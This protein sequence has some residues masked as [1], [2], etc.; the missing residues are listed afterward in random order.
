[1]DRRND[2]SG[3]P[4]KT[5]R[6][7]RLTF[8]ECSTRQHHYMQVVWSD[9][10]MS[11]APMD[12]S[13]Q[14][15]G[16]PLLPFQDEPPFALHG[17]HLLRR[18]VGGLRRGRGHVGALS[19][20]STAAV[21]VVVGIVLLLVAAYMYY[22]LVYLKKR[23]QRPARPKPNQPQSAAPAQ[24]AHTKPSTPV[25]GN[26]SVVTGCAAPVQAQH[27][28]AQEPPMYPQPHPA[29]SHAPAEHAHAPPCA[30]YPYTHAGSPQPQQA[31]HQPP[32]GYPMA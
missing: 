7:T 25:N 15:Q 8:S 14:L 24:A 29:Y 9:T 3:A 1:M 10:T 19:S 4:P 18:R 21:F 5:S 13:N 30:Q 2:R 17:R 31:S 12:R 6:T 22:K 16:M 11:A 26:G 20:G 32:P 23:K 28:Y 27:A